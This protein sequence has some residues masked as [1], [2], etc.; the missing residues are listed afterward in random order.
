M[1][2]LY[3]FEGEV[4]HKYDSKVYELFLGCFQSLPLA[5]IL[6]KKVFVCHGG[7][8]KNDGVTV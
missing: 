5:Y 3:G 7:L 8:F 2:K 1:T 6:G 4:L